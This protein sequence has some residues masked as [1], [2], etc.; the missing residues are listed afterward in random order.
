M[1]ESSKGCV[2]KRVWA[3]LWKLRIPNKIKV[4]GWRACNEILPTKMNLAKRRII[5]EAACPIC[6]RFV[7]TAVHLLW[8]CDAARDVWA[9]SLKSLQKG[10]HGMID[11]F[12]LLEYLMERLALEDLELVLVQA[13]LIWNQRNRV[14]WNIS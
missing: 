3:V 6:T 1:A 10:V 2:G 11:M 13:W 14:R 7:E 8:E 4:F 9:G 5:E 12:Q